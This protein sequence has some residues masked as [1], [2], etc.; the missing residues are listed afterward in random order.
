M[1]SQ[2]D[3]LLEVYGASQLEQSFGVSVVLK[4]GRQQSAAFTATWSDQKYEVFDGDNLTTIVLLRD[5]VF[6]TANVL[7]EDVIASP[8]DGDFLIVEDSQRFQIM[9]PGPRM[10]AVEKLPGDYRWLVHT[11]RIST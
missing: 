9:P 1:P 6:S 5:F 2:A 7:I 11:K 3:Q 4:R 8:K 10:P